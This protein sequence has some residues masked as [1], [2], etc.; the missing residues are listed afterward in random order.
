MT[1][2]PKNKLTLFQ[3]RATEVLSVFKMYGMDIYIPSAIQNLRAIVEELFVG[4]PTAR[5]V[6]NHSH[7][8]T[9]PDSERSTGSVEE[10]MVSGTVES[11]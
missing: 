3:M 4:G 7:S 11:L 8:M 2:P 9:S 6:E 10:G 5:S 1:L